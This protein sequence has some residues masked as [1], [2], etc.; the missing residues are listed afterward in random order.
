MNMPASRALRTGKKRSAS[1]VEVITLDSSFESPH[2]TFGPFELNRYA[3]TWIVEGGG[4]TSLD[5]EAIVTSPGTVLSMLPGMSLRHDW[6]AARSF[7]SFI[8]FEFPS[9]PEDVAEGQAAQ[10]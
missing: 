9:L 2:S 8:V 7:Q 10:R 4:V 5:G 1:G 6:G 3:L